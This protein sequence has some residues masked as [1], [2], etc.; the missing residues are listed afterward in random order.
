MQQSVKKIVIGVV[1]VGVSLFGAYWMQ[2][3]LQRSRAS[4]T[5]P[6]ASFSIDGPTV[7]PGDSFDLIVQLNPNLTPFYSFDI[8][9]TYDPA[10]VV[11][12]TV[13]VSADSTSTLPASITPLS[14]KAD[15]TV[16]V[17]LL[18]GEGTTNIDEST[19]T[20]RITAIRDNGANDPF[21]GRDILK[22]VKVAFT[23]K[24]GQTLPLDF[25]WIDPDPA[26]ITISDSFEK[27][28]LSYTGAPTPTTDNA[29]P[30]S[31]GAPGLTEAP[32]ITPDVIGGGTKCGNVMCASNSKCYQPPVPTC[33]PSANTC[34]ALIQPPMICVTLGPDEPPIPYTTPPGGG[35]GTDAVTTAITPRKDLLL[36]NSI[37][38]YPAPFRYEQ[39]VKLEKGTYT[40]TLGAKMWTK[41]GSGL[42]IGFICNEDTCGNKKKGE[43]LL[44]TPSFPQKAAFSE[45]KQSV[46]IPDDADNKEWKVRIF[47]E[48]GSECEIDYLSLED[49]WGSERLSN[50]QFESGKEQYDPRSQPAEWEVD[51]TANMYGTIDPAISNNGAL[52][53]NNSSK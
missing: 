48:D 33:P 18:S 11:P 12:G 16:D 13:E 37:G 49:A 6:T 44:N 9:F 21:S 29:V 8:A 41:R 28:D 39:V 43:F 45:L 1:L 26:K 34:P 15:G 51:A 40:L 2:Q 7:N 42:V 50:P 47:C 5:A 17:K 20:V 23:M 46:T 35:G 53:I 52:T 27:K 19:H 24:E 30:G 25:K 10:K 38:T 4:A 36:I 3:Y 14:T 31:T 32:A 22:V